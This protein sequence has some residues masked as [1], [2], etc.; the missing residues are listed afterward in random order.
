MPPPV[1]ALR[2]FF[3][4]RIARKLPGSFEEHFR[5]R[6]ASTSASGALQKSASRLLKQSFPGRARWGWRTQGHGRMIQTSATFS[7]R[8]SG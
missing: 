4:E 5:M 8:L 3:Y 2:R 6:I 1:C 7:A